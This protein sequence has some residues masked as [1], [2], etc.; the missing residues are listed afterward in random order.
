MFARGESIQIDASPE[1]VFDYLADVSKHGEWAADGIVSQRELG[2]DRGVGVRFT[3]RVNVLGENVAR[4]VV[5][6]ADR[7][8]RFVYEVED[9][10]GHWRWTMTFR[11]EGSGTQLIHAFERIK[12]P[13]WVRLGQIP[14][15]RFAG[16]PGIRRGLANIKAHLGNDRSTQMG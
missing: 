15:Y 1:A 6:E 11:L 14:I 7:P 10:T 4:G 13:L 8:R 5:V 2:P 3:S 9:R 16:R 12:A